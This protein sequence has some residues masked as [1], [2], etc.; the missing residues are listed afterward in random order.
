MDRSVNHFCRTISSAFFSTQRRQIS[1]LRLDSAENVECCLDGCD[2]NM[3][4]LGLVSCGT[5]VPAMAMA[6]V[7]LIMFPPSLS[8]SSP[9]A[10]VC[11]PR[12]L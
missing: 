4:L 2:V 11:L 3:K 5:D 9:E 6:T 12:W 10:A 8:G 1:R 7:W